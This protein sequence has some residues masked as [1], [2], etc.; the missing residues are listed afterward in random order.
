[1][2]HGWFFCQSCV[3]GSSQ[4][5]GFVSNCFWVQKASNSEWL[6]VGIIAAEIQRIIP[7][8]PVSVDNGWMPSFKDVLPA[9]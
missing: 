1:M 7:E 8:Q 3:F 2:F 9:L 4:P 5:F 6:I